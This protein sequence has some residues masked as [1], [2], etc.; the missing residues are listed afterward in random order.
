MIVRPRRVGRND[1]MVAGQL[2]C[3]VFVLALCT[4]A[5]GEGASSDVGASS[6]A[7]GSPGFVCGSGR[8]QSGYYCEAMIGGALNPL[9]DAGVCPSGTVPA[10]NGCVNAQHKCIATTCTDCACLGG[11]NCS[12][13]AEGNLTVTIPT[14]GAASGRFPVLHRVFDRTAAGNPILVG[15]SI[16]GLGRGDLAPVSP[17]EVTSEGARV[18]IRRPDLLPSTARSSK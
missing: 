3:L 4:C 2:S 7:N 6:G 15:L 14:P 16:V 1:W 5:A 17:G 11:P 13:D 10:R 18:E 12:Q 8:C 9:P